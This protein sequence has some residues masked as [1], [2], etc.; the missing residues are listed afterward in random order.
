MT[1][2]VIQTSTATAS[3][4]H[5][6]PGQF[7]LSAQILEGKKKRLLAPTQNKCS[8]FW[9]QVKDLVATSFYAHKFKDL[10]N[11]RELIG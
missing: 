3:T 6:T 11:Q 2:N 9:V 4:D 7:E 5:H 1:F 8:Q 10:I